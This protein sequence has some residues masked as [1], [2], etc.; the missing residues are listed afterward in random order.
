MLPSRSRCLP[1]RSCSLSSMNHSSRRCT[2]SRFLRWRM[3]VCVMIRQV[4]YCRPSRRA[5]ACS[6]LLSYQHCCRQP[7]AP[8]QTGEPLSTPIPEAPFPPIF[9]QD[10]PHHSPQL[11]LIRIT[12]LLEQRRRRLRA[13]RLP[14]LHA[15]H[16][17]V[18]LHDVGHGLRVGRRAGPAAPDGVVDL[19]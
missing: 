5:W 19:G 15:V 18:V 7:S 12:Q 2:Y 3:T 6:P 9:H 10:S 1:L 17:E 8:I 14:V 16:A 13:R 11:V 4:G